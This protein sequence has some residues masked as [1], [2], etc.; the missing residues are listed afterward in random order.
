VPQSLQTINEHQRIVS[1]AA[2]L[3]TLSSSS[4]HD[5]IQA[6]ERAVEGPIDVL[7]NCHGIQRRAK[8]VEFGEDMWN[9]VRN[10]SPF[11]LLVLSIFP[12]FPIKLLPNW[13]SVPTSPPRFDR[14]LV[15]G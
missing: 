6:A 5:F 3:S 9:E 14:L 8:S 2:D 15:M 11:F 13:T 4:A 7:V 10:P 1:V 12:T